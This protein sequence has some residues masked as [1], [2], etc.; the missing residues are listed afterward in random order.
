MLDKI[1]NWAAQ[2]QVRITEQKNI[3]YGIQIKLEQGSDK[4]SLALYQTGKF[5]LQGKD[6]ALKFRLQALLG[7]DS[8]PNKTAS[9]HATNQT[10]DHSH[11]VWIGVDESGKGDFFG[12]LAVSAVVVHRKLA[13]PLSSLGVTDSKR[14]SDARIR[15]MA[16]QLLRKLKHHTIVLMPTEYNQEYQQ[17]QN[18]NVL[19]GSL[20]AQCIAALYDERVEMFLSDQFANDK[21]LLQKSISKHNLPVEKLRQAPRAESDLAVACAS[22]LA[23]YHFIEALDRLSEKFAMSFPKGAG[24]G[25]ERAAAEFRQTHGIEAFSQVAKL[26]FKTFERLQ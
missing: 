18:L 4:I 26:H 2:N 8:N 10:L 14:L 24:E 13:E 25:V 11:Q 9:P 23:R 7:I 17:I 3:A 5:L 21:G 19:L 12:P 1:K 16:P 15:E 20:H 6:S 22:I